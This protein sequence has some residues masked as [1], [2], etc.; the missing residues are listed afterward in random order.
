M[1]WDKGLRF[2]EGVLQT[3][4]RMFSHPLPSLFSHQHLSE[5]LNNLSKFMQP[6]RSG[7]LS[8]RGGPAH[9]SVIVRPFVS[10]TYPCPQAHLRHLAMAL[11]MHHAIYLSPDNIPHSSFSLGLCTNR[12]CCLRLFTLSS[13]KK[14]MS[15]EPTHS[16]AQL[17]VSLFGRVS[18]H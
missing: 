16:H 12:S 6:V 18:L 8:P 2:P 7:F 4:S 11:C 14:K 17:Q 13:L 9:F 3:I 10:G 15:S 5:R 1:V